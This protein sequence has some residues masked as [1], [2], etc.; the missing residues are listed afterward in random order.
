M[1]I[2]EQMGS[3]CDL[4]SLTQSDTDTDTNLVLPKISCSLRSPISLSFI[5]VS[6]HGRGSHQVYYPW[7]LASMFSIFIHSILSILLNSESELDISISYDFIVISQRLSLRI[8]LNLPKVL[9]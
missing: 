1:L 2:L 9:T 7:P 3:D 4:L 6:W 5:V 8:C